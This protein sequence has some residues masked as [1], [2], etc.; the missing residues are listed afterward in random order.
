MFPVNIEPLAATTYNDLIMTITPP[1]QACS[2]SQILHR[3]ILC[4]VLMSFDHLHDF[5]YRKVWHRQSF[6]VMTSLH[7]QHSTLI[8]SSKFKSV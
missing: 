5:I 7:H 3:D 1:T 8:A 2:L 4:E 6:K